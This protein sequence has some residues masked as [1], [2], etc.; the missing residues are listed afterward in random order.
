MRGSL[1]GLTHGIRSTASGQISAC[2][3]FRSPPSVGPRPVWNTDATFFARQP[4]VKSRI[5][6]V[7]TTI[8][9]SLWFLP[10]IFTVAMS[11]VAMLL[12]SAERKGAF[13]GVGWAA[14]LEGGSAESAR[15][16][17]SGV[18]GGL[19]TV[20]GVAFSVMIVALEL[21]SS[22]YTP[23]VLPNFLADRA[24]QVVIGILIG[25]FTYSLLVLRVIDS[26]SS[27]GEPFVPR[28]A[29][30]GGMLLALVSVGTII[31]FIN[32]AAQSIQIAWILRSATDR[33]LAQVERLFPED[34]GREDTQ[35]PTEDEVP[36]DH[37]SILAPRSGYL[38]AIDQHYIFAFGRSAEA[39]V[40]VEHPIG[41]FILEG[42]SLARC[43]PSASIDEKARKKLTRAFTLGPERT[44][45][46][47]YELTL[48]E[49]SD[50]AV[51]ALSPGIN[52]PTT[53]QHCIDRLS[54]LLLALALRHAPSRIRTEE[55]RVHVIVR[56]LPF[57]RALETAFAPILHFGASNP[58][59]RDR[60][61]DRLNALA[62]LVPE[63]R[64]RAIRELIASVHARTTD[65]KAPLFVEQQ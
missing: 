39:V 51:R 62:E 9:D 55:G 37:I 65:E 10:S 34:F 50:V 63:Q 56:D 2:T 20:T 61:I 26:A 19:I 42:Q 32:H 24:N 11:G 25:T 47:D 31:F 35:L 21:S 41:A 22:Q 7:W 40:K 15:A 48:I 60:L 53:A 1:W 13:A 59:I 27:G 30:A 43:W 64:R 28:I 6:I 23:R 17:L 44:R 3:P 57:E 14:V 4:R 46:Q 29:I 36:P 33:A 38:Q 5:V 54:Q 45:E 58:A 16:L 49:I 52:D 18:A 12:L 8:R